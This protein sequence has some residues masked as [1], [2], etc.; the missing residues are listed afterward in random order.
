[1][2]MAAAGVH[3][4]LWLELCLQPV[5]AAATHMSYVRLWFRLCLQPGGAAGS[6]QRSSAA[7]LAVLEALPCLMWHVRRKRLPSSSAAW[8][9]NCK[10][11]GR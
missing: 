4:Q 7:Q 6:A 9:I 1:M 5:G 2:N 11:A 3:V 10:Q 8:T